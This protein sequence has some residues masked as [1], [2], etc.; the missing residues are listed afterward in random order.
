MLQA[1]EQCHFQQELKKL[2]PVKR[3]YFL[4]VIHYESKLNIYRRQCL[5]YLSA[6]GLKKV[7]N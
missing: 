3:V 2:P 1:R 7:V 6:F 4:Q 5:A